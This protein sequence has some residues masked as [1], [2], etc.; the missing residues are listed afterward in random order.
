MQILH[1]SNNYNVKTSPYCNRC[2]ITGIFMVIPGDVE[3]NFFFQL[4]TKQNFNLAP[5]GLPNHRKGQ[6]TE[7]TPKN[8]SM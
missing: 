4:T 3:L 6:M 7:I 1:N 8:K 5:L 2:N